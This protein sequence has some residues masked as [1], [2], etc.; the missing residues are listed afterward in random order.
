[1]PGFSGHQGA[2]IMVLSPE[3][4]C[5][6]YVM[7]TFLNKNKVDYIWNTLFVNFSCLFKITL[8]CLLCLHL[9]MASLISNPKSLVIR[10]KTEVGRDIQM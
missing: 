4:T 1:M 9:G 3:T 6:R 5:D 8:L 10:I 2:N 7:V